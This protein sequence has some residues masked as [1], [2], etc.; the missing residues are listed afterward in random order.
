MGTTAFSFSFFF[1]ILTSKLQATIAGQRPRPRGLKT[2]PRTDKKYTDRQ[3]RG[4]FRRRV[5]IS[6]VRSSFPEKRAQTPP[7]SRGVNLGCSHLTRARTFP[8]DSRSH[9]QPP[10]AAARCS[11]TWSTQTRVDFYH[12]LFFFFKLFFL[13]FCLL[14]SSAT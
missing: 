1:L 12:R 14:P 2:P 6:D 8:E 13:F 11:R 5:P 4:S 9:L 7:P 3:K 10:S